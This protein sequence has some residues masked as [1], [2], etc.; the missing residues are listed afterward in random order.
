MIVGRPIVCWDDVALGLVVGV[1]LGLLL[2]IV[3]DVMRWK[4]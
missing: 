1:V 4:R 3:I 2:V